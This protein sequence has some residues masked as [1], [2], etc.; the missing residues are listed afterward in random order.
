MLIFA[1]SIIT[2]NSSFAVEGTVDLNSIL[3]AEE[4][5]DE[6]DSETETASENIEDIQEDTEETEDDNSDGN[7]NSSENA[8]SN[9][10]SSNSSSLGTSTLQTNNSNKAIKTSTEDSKLPQTGQLDN[11][12]IFLPVVIFGTLAVIAFLKLNKYKMYRQ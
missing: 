6:N 10:S 12:V 7:S 11:I 8:S 9:S 2:S 1:F 3:G 5:N 4:S